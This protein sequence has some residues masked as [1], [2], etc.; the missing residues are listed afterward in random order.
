MLT[1]LSVLL[2]KY[3]FYVLRSRATVPLKSH[4][5]SFRLFLFFLVVVVCFFIYVIL[6]SHLLHGPNLSARAPWLSS[7]GV[8]L[9]LDHDKYINIRCVYNVKSGI[10]F[11]W[12]TF[13]LASPPPPPHPFTQGQSAKF[14]VKGGLVSSLNQQTLKV[15]CLA[16]F[17]EKPS[18]LPPPPSITGCGAF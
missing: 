7:T 10:I 16:F 4:S 11:P 14:N 3:V 13:V 17:S 18:S 8:L 15:N 9:S 2:S 6:S 5:R 12:T 1:V